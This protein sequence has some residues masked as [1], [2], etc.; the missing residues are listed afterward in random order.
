[1]KAEAIRAGDIPG[2]Q[3]RCRRDLP[4]PPE[5]AWE[6]LTRVERLQSWLCDRARVDL[7]PGGGLLLE[8]AAEESLPLR[9]EAETLGIEPPRRWTL[10]FRRLDAGWRAPTRLT[11]ELT[12]TAAGSE[13]SVLQQGFEHLSLST[14]LTVW[15]EYRRRWRTACER[16]EAAISGPAG[17]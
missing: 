12:S 4:V 2:V 6:W 10:S 9:E 16:L 13:L 7:G 14:C 15:E 17:S 1:M 8:R 11:L 5:A 3:L